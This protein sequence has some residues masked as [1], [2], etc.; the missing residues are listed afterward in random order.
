MIQSM[1][2]VIWL[3]IKVHGTCAAA[4]NLKEIAFKL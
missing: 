3:V 2:K 4:I 1:Q